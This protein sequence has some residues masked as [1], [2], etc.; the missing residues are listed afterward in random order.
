MDGGLASVLVVVLTACSGQRSES[1]SGKGRLASADPESTEML[2][3]SYGYLVTGDPDFTRMAPNYSTL[4]PFTRD[5]AFV[6]ETS[7]EAAGENPPPAD[8]PQYFHVRVNRPLAVRFIV[9]DSLGKGLITYE[10]VDV[11]VGTYTFGSEGWPLPQVERT[12]GHRWV[13]AYWVGDR[14][15]RARYQFLVDDEGHFIHMPEE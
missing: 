9:A 2:D 3:W 11:P 4:R 10:F 14:R 1:S 8:K 5:T 6:V 12:A 13:Y 15:F 7:S